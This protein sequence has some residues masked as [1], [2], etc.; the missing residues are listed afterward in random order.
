MKIYLTGFMGSGKTT[1]GKVLAH[2]L[3]YAFL[4]LDDVIEKQRGKSVQQLFQESGEDFFR[5]LE[6]RALM[7]TESLTR[8]VIATG[9]GTPCFL[10]NMAW[11]NRHGLSI[12]LKVPAKVL[13]DRLSRQASTRPLISGLQGEEL[14][15]YIERKLT[16][17]EPFYEKSHFVC[18]AAAP[19]QEIQ[20][21]LLDYFRRFA[22]NLPGERP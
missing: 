2:G 17:R 8:T 14:L 19:V 6:N 11:M 5:D 10:N 9:G 12:Y 22:D 16:E 7:E 21:S 20:E 15:L 1:I 18:L 13:F 3:G 4:D